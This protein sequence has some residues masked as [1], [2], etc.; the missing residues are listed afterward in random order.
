MNIITD[1]MG[2]MRSYTDDEMREAWHKTIHGK[3]PDLK[4]WK[5]KVVVYTEGC[6]PQIKYTLRQDVKN[7][8]EEMDERYGM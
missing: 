5:A 8:A 1:K 4:Y 3:A 7:W 2:R 6:F